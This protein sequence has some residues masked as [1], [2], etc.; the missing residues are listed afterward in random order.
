MRSNDSAVRKA[1]V[2]AWE[3][4]SGYINFIGT[5]RSMEMEWMESNGYKNYP[6]D[7]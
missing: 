4:K 7:D 2:V 6:V 1:F 3:V 5:A